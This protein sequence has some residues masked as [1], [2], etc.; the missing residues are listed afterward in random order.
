VVV[1]VALP[2][3]AWELELMVDLVVVVLTEDHRDQTQVELQIEMQ[4][5]LHLNRHRVIMVGQ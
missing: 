3:T 5:V 4:G 1:A 2:E